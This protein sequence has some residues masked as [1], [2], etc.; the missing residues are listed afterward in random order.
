MFNPDFYPT[1]LPT[2][3]TML[4]GITIKG[5]IFYEPQ[6]GKGNIVD[7]LLQHEAADVI[8]SEKDKDLQK[9]VSAKCR[10]IAEDFLTV[11]SDKI[12]HVDFI[13]M[14]PPFSEAVKHVLHAFAIA[15]AGCK[16]ISLINSS[17][18]E[19][20]YTNDRKELAS[21]IDL[22]G[23]TEDLGD[24]FSMAER[25][26]G[27]KVTKITLDKPA[28][29]K[30]N[31]FEG[32]FM[33]DDPAEE[34]GFGIMPYNAVRDIVNRYVAAVRLYDE[35]LNL[36]VKMNS[37][38]SGFYGNELAF[39]CTEKGTPKLRND[40]KKDMQKAG[41]QYVFDKLNMRKFATR[42]LKEDI[43]KFV[44]Q[45]SQIPFTMRNIYRMLDIVIGTQSQRMDK[46]LLEVF[47]KITEHH[48]ENRFNV[49]GWK[50]NSHYLVGKKFIL[51]YMISPAKEY[52]YTSSYYSSLKNSWDGI[53]PDFEKALCHVSGTDY[54]QIKGVNHSINRNTYGEWYNST[55]LKYK[56][57]KN[58]NM[59]FEFND[60]ELWAKFNQHIARIKGY[61]LYEPKKQTTY[62]ERQTGRS[63][64][65]E[66]TQKTEGYTPTVLFEM[67]ILNKEAV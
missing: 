41:W 30:S 9:I 12:S 31:E 16:V 28:A 49:K 36:G 46:A 38:L 6:A 61:P 27:V 51:P 40:F 57:Y 58:G 10:M 34:Q 2:I 15:P 1:D 4:D 13:V 65:K 7:Y 14:N 59:H 17:N 52:G 62:Q 67:D 50:T 25:K 29:E 42:G 23:F 45:Q 35:Q 60:E 3:E 37:L 48:H 39:N 54:D 5:K 24:C 11:T 8:C 47:E 64:Q 32:F 63:Q 19:N 66:R 55:F 21:I 26:T 18:L 53:I 43:N 20:T 44:E 22:Y 56:G 33:E